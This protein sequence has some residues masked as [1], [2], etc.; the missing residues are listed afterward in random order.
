MAGSHQQNESPGPAAGA[1]SLPAG[2]SAQSHIAPGA[3]VPAS[4]QIGPFCRIGEGVELGERC[5]LDSHV[6]IEG[7]AR[8][9]DDNHFFPFSTIGLP[10]QDLTYRG[11]PTRLEIGSHNVVREFC[12][13]HRGT[14]KGG[15]I[16]RIGDH[17]LLMA[18]VHVAHD[19]QV[20]SHIIM[21]NCAT[22]G[23]HVEVG[24]YATVGAFVP[25]HQF[26]RIGR[27]AYIGGGT[28]VTQDV[29]PYSKTSTTRENHAFGAN[30]IGLER[31]GLAAERVQALQRAFR[32]LLNSGLNTSQA[33][34]RLRAEP[35]TEEVKE[36][37]EF[38][39]ASR[40]GVIK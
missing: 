19:C 25:V 13:L 33:L 38:I 1:P 14:L 30:R 2:G 34:E 17:N 6:V 40:R 28:I 9:G 21:A 16:T 4:C 11:E 7:P 31:Q 35:M 18:Y 12:S 8:I 23:G 26:V 29:L 32:L 36:L 10:P 22:L 15:G 39:A 3:R 27:Y 24:D 37:A 5:R 20:G